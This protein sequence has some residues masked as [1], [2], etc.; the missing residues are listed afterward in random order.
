MAID[1]SD[2]SRQTPK[3]HLHARNIQRCD[4]VCIVGMVCASYID[5]SV[6]DCSNSIANALELLQSCIKPSMCTTIFAVVLNVILRYVGACYV[7]CRLHQEGCDSLSGLGT[8]QKKTL[9]CLRFSDSES[10][11]TMLDCYFVSVLGCFFFVT[12]WSFRS[13]VYFL[14]LRTSVRPSVRKLVI[15]HMIT[16]HRF[17]LNSPNLHQTFIM[18]YPQLVLKMGA[19]DCDLQ[20][21]FGH[22]DS[23]F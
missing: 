1:S 23:E 10:Y 2:Y 5:G 18:G 15:V 21:Y 19:I 6:Q 3:A 22:S 4:C 20:G 11:Y 17:E 7:R 12:P 13:K 9:F 14:C 16:Q 8:E